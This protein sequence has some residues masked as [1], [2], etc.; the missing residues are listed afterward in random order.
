MLHYL[1]ADVPEKRHAMS[2]ARTLCAAALLAA[3]LP[4]WAQTA[5][6]LNG[7]LGTKALLMIGG[8]PHLTA[9][10]ETWQ[11]VKVIS[12]GGDQALVL[13]DGQRVT[14][15]LGDAPVSVGQATPGNN[16]DRIALTAGAGGHFITL[17]SINNRP[18]TFMVDTGASVVAI[19]QAEADRLGLDYKQGRQVRMATANGVITGW[20]LR[21]SSLRI[22][23]VVSYEV[24]AVVIPATMPQVLLGNSYLSRFSMR[25]DGDQ[26]MLIKR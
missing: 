21:L 12:T 18:V 25:R 3:A 17:G 5:V 10:G 7:V 8:A 16:G 2:R 14:L 24:E 4:A 6:S 20:T 9:P 23:D 26:M 11:G 13:V 1:S 15:R 19:G 22:G